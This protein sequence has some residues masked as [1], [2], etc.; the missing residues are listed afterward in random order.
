VTTRPTP[1]ESKREVSTRDGYDLW[2]GTYDAY[3]NPLVKLESPVV[4][5]TLGDVSGLRILDVGCG[6]GRHAKRLAEV[7]AWVTGID[8]S[9]GMLA[10]ARTKASDRVRFVV[11]DLH[12]R[13]PFQEGEFDR[14]IC[15]LVFDHIR[16]VA[17]VLSEMRRVCRRD[18][19]ILVTTLHPTMLLAGV[20]ARF[21][22]AQTGE[23][24]WLESVHHQVS[25]YV[26]ASVSAGLR[27]RSMS[28][29]F[30]DEALTAISPNAEKYL[31]WPLLMVMTFER[32]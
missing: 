11:G 14:V 3:D 10:R 24:V 15:C 18:G 26:N 32:V 21:T 6:T 23:K 30:V 29:H 16:D 19:V 13:L 20:Q 4:A 27:L 25:D 1:S 7:G 17:E 22:D 12:H 28:E 5:A 9:A 31:G 8:F 2:S